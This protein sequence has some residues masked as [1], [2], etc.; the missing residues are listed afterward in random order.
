[1]ADGQATGYLLQFWRPTARNKRKKGMAIGKRF[2][3][4]AALTF[5]LFGGYAAVPAQAQNF[6]ARPVHVIVPFAPGGGV[7]I[8]ARLIAPKLRAGWGQPGG[9]E[10]KSG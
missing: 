5:A 10:T 9:I 8:V 7:D 1:M 4:T 2:W 6:P 3:P